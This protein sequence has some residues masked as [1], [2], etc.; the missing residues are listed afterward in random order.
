MKT[1]NKIRLSKLDKYVRFVFLVS[2][3]ILLPGVVGRFISDNSFTD[4][5]KIVI[6]LYWIIS[7]MFSLRRH[8]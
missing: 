2:S 6:Y 4:G 5:F 8:E 3:L 7:T 1:I